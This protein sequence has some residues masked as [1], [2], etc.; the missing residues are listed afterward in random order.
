MLKNMNNILKK[1][2]LTIKEIWI[3]Y[4][5]YHEGNFLNLFSPWHGQP[6][7]C[8]I[9]PRNYSFMRSSMMTIVSMTMI[10][11]MMMVTCHWQVWWWFRWRR[12]QP[13]AKLMLKQQQCILFYIYCTEILK[14][15]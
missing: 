4:K 7:T 3:K 8:S 10:K 6:W 13:G 5:R 1:C 11:I 15:Y 2:K 9:G 12:R 14:K